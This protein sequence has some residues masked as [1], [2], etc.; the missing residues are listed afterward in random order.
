MRFRQIVQCPLG[1]FWLSM[2]NALKGAAL[3]GLVFPGLGQIMLKYY[4]RGMVLLTA[5]LASLAV[6]LVEAVERALAVLDKLVLEGATIDIQAISRAAVQVTRASGDFTFNLA[7][8][9]LVL[10]WLLGTVDAYRIGTKIDGEEL[11]RSKD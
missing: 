6:M 3:S 11:S 8:A 5:V 9:V 1:E 10:C 2:S 7:L 4:K